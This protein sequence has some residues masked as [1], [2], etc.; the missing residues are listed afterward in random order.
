MVLGVA[1]IAFWQQRKTP[2]AWFLWYLL[3]GS[4]A[5]SVTRVSA[6]VLHPV[7]AGSRYF[8]F[9]YILLSWLLLQ[10][11]CSRTNRLWLRRAA[12]VILV[13][14]TVNALPHLWRSHEDLNWREHVASSIDFDSYAIPIQY[15]GP[16]CSSWY[17]TVSGAQ[18]ARLLSN[19]RL[20]AWSRNLAVYPYTVVQFNAAAV[21]PHAASRQAVQNRGWQDATTSSTAPAGF[22]VLR[23]TGRPGARSLTLRLNRGDRVLFRSSQRAFELT[24]TIEGADHTFAGKLPPSTAWKWLEFSNRRLPATFTVTL[25]DQG[26]DEQQW[27]EAA[28]A[29]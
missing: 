16:A 4:I 15:G 27:A 21:Q 9:P 11:A 6:T 12:Q 28:F 2:A 13:V 10:I 19:D 25:Q 17:L 26:E 8:F 24:A 7:H 20:R 1:G 5:L 18:A 23:S 22:A 3:P 29:Q 14:A